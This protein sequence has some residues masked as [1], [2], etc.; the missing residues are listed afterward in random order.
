MSDALQ[1]ALPHCVCTQFWGEKLSSK[2]AP[3]I[4]QRVFPNRAE[5]EAEAAR[6]RALYPD[7]SR[8]L[9]WVAP[10]TKPITPTPP[11]FA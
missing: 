10:T 8:A 2:R 6:L 1:A 11:R 3:K 9:I 4:G 5:A 7:R